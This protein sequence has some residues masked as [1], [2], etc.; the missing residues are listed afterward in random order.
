MN[1][2]DLQPID[3]GGQLRLLPEE[4]TDD[5]LSKAEAQQGICTG[6]R[7]KHYDAPRYALV[8]T[9][10]A[11]GSLSQ[12][13]VSRIAGVSR[14]LVAG[15]VK[16]QASDIEPLK[17][18]LAGQLSTL[19]QLC[20]ERATEMVLDDDAKISLKDLMVGAGVSAEKFLLM[21]GQA[22]SITEFRPV[23][24][25][26]DEFEAALRKAKRVDAVDVE[27]IE[28]GMAAEDSLT[29]GE[30][31][32]PDPTAAEPVAGDLEGGAK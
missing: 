20:V 11:E 13:Q 32:E 24:P 27:V 31:I 10:L 30:S 29:K 21:T 22:T 7:L 9:L 5:M 1:N 4:V 17:A 26:E 23:D 3:P 28:M 14:N 19:H 18:K 6:D 25:G 2:R 12:R 16:T 8:C 15:M